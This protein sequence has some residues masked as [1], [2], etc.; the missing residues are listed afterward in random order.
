V[1]CSKGKPDRKRPSSCPEN[2]KKGVVE[3][4]EKKGKLSSGEGEM[5]L[6]RLNMSGEL[7]G[8]RGWE[9]S[10]AR[11]EGTVG[12]GAAGDRVLMFVND[13]YL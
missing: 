12:G 3:E 11:G 6:H 2:G 7:G 9:K 13:P 8:H 1:E 4:M 10:R 5:R